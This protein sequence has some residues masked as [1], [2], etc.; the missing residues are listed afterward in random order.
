MLQ[1]KVMEVTQ[2]LQPMQDMAFFL[3]IEVKNQGEELYQVIITTKQL[4]EGPVNDA[5]S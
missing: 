3:F 1:S 2:R 4:P 5:V